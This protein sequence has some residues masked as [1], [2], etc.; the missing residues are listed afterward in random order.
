MPV[1]DAHD[2]R[3]SVVSG[4]YLKLDRGQIRQQQSLMA[5]DTPQA[6]GIKCNSGAS[7]GVVHFGCLVGVYVRSRGMPMLHQTMH[8]WSP[9]LFTNVMLPVSVTLPKAL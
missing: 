7:A 3:Q 2:E 5:F 9:V 6:A 8:E 4:P 1:G